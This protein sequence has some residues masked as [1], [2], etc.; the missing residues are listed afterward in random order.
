[1]DRENTPQKQRQKRSSGNRRNSSSN[2]PTN[3]PQSLTS[4]ASLSSVAGPSRAFRG[5]QRPRSRTA[6]SPAA[7]PA[8]I[9]SKPPPVLLRPSSGAPVSGVLYDPATDSRPSRAGP[10][11][12]HLQVNTRLNSAGQ[13]ASPTDRRT[14][15]GSPGVPKGVLRPS[16]PSTALQKIVPPPTSVKLITPQM[17]FATDLSAK[18][19]PCLE[20]MNF[21]VV[22][23][24][25]LEGVGKSTV[26]SL[27]DDSKDKSKFSTQS[28]ENLVAGRH[29]T[30]GVDLAV[31]LAGGA[32]HPTV[33][34]DSQ[35]LLSSSMLVD[36]LSRNESPRFGALSPEQQVEVTSYQIAV[37]LCA[38]CHYVVVVHD[39]LAFQL[40][41]ADLLRQVEQKFS[42]CRLPSVSGNS[43]QHAAR[44]LY[45]AN[46]YADSE[47]L[48][49]ENELLSAHERA[50]EAAWSQAFVCV[51]YKL[52]HYCTEP[53]SDDTGHAATFVL[54]HKQQLLRRSSS[55]MK[56]APEQSVSSSPSTSKFTKGRGKEFMSSSSKYTDFDDAADAFRSFVLS[57]PGSPSFTSQ[58]ASQSSTLPGYKASPPPHPLS[59][60]EWLS[61]A[62]RV[63]EAVRKS[64]CFT[65]EY[66]S[67]RDYH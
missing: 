15:V 5:S 34:L 40:S 28:L 11:Q 58:G 19:G 51:P 66:A 64:S 22:G 18:L 54:P 25:G 39:G 23:V 53:D 33:L 48:Y 37:F 59:L 65:A 56:D 6:A 47:L 42:Q 61:N 67:S 62:S 20:M 16:T 52:S 24:L 29:E 46:N 7:A 26:L 1:M 30:T 55:S 41:V 60:R 38:I 49:R 44:L 27:L 17:Q 10:G 8:A 57:L 43:Q 63:F 4:R 21:T 50:L 36:L 12:D 31:S 14:R 35:P 45:V 2:G 9:L 3:H 13:A 32:G